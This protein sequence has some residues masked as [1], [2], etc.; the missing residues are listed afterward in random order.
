MP[1]SGVIGGGMPARFLILACLFYVVLLTGVEHA[2]AVPSYNAS[3]STATFTHDPDLGIAGVPALSATL[4]GTGTLTPRTNPKSFSPTSTMPTPSSYQ[5]ATTDTRPSNAG[6]SVAK[7]SVAHVTNA[8]TA[9][10]K[11]AS[12]TGITQ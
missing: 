1:Y 3:L 8:T 11:I 7:A 10:V 6:N 5:F 4:V 2:S 12:G 9:A